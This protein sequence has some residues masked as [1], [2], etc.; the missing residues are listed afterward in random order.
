[1]RESYKNNIVFKRYYRRTGTRPPRPS[2]LHLAQTWGRL[3][4]ETCHREYLSFD[5]A[6]LK[7]ELCFDGV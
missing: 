2:F 3:L 7:V 6:G 1:M 5:H 4:I